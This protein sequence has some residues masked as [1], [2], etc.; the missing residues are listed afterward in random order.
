MILKTHLLW[1]ANVWDSNFILKIHFFVYLFPD[2]NSKSF[3]VEITDQ[4]QLLESRLE[5]LKPKDTST[6]SSPDSSP[7]QILE[8]GLESKNIGLAHL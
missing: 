3:P 1:S 5:S 2:L 8:S 6:D 4:V 7:K